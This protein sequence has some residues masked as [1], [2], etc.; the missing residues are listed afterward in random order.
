MRPRDSLIVEGRKFS[1]LMLAAAF[2]QKL[3]DEY[4]RPIMVYERVPGQPGRLVEKCRPMVYIN[5]KL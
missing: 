3:A 1:D 5:G 2:G 4:Q